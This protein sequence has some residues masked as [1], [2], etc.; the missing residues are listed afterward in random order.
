MTP[1]IKFV[2]ACFGMSLVITYAWWCHF[3]TLILRGRLFLIRDQ[4]WD[5]MCA[6]GMLDDPAHLE[7]RNVINSLISAAST[8]NWLSFLFILV[9]N[10]DFQV[11][12]RS[13]PKILEIRHAR[14]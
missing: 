8:M 2:L 12:M 9:T 11:V 14:R 3:R 6:K 13:E 1:E 10:K 7:M 4:L 5:V